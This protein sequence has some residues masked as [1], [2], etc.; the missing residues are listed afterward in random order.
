MYIFKIPVTTTIVI[1]EILKTFPL[2]KE[3]NKY[4][5]NILF[6]TV[7]EVI[8]WVVRQGKLCAIN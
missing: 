1:S 5:K 4:S 6:N 7:L 2:N 8:S 3:Q